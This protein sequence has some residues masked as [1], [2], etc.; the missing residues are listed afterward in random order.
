M[1]YLN[2]LIALEQAA[3]NHPNNAVFK[4]PGEDGSGWKDISYKTFWDDITRFAVHRQAK[5]KPKYNF[6]TNREV[7]GLWYVFFLVSL[8]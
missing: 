2:H 5:L 1:G 7:V 4:V 8:T 3:L 6:V